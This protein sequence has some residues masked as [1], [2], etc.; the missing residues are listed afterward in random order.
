MLYEVITMG[1]KIWFN[2]KVNEG[3]TFYFTIPY[4][5]IAEVA[6]KRKRK[7]KLPQKESISEYDWRNKT[8]LIA[9]DEQNNIIYLSE[10]LRRT[11]ATILEVKNGKKAVELVEKNMD[12][13]SYNFV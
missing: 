4:M 1:G 6:A 7:E 5:E 10:I 3:S 11:G 13:S 12:I 2:S 9:E 8:I